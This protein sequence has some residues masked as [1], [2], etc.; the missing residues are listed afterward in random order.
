MKNLNFASS[1]WEKLSL[2][3]CVSVTAVNRIHLFLLIY[4]VS[5]SFQPYLEDDDHSVITSNTVPHSQPVNCN[6]VY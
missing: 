4:E 1:L 5:G 2:G 3:M 6:E